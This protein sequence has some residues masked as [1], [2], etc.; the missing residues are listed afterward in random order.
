[1]ILVKVEK[2]NS[3]TC[4]LRSLL[5][6]LAYHGDIHSNSA[7]ILSSFKKICEKLSAI[8]PQ[9]NCTLVN[10]RVIATQIG[11][12]V[13]NDVSKEKEAVIESL[14]SQKISTVWYGFANTFDLKLE[15]Y[16]P[17]ASRESLPLEKVVGN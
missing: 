7:E 13:Q 4:E 12:R 10:K 6:G 5:K 16:A 15:T 2:L 17:Q 9:Y 8:E 3:D 11:C 14:N 1:M